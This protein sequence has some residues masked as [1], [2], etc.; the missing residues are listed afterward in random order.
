MSTPTKQTPPADRRPPA[1][2]G[3]RAV[4]GSA[5]VLAVDLYPRRRWLTIG[6]SA[7][8]GFL[9]TVVW[10]AE[11]VDS[12][13]GDTVANS[14]LGHD[15]KA[16]PIAGVGA[17]ILF[18]L[19][20]GLAGTFTACNV[21]VF[22][23]MAPALRGSASRMGR[24]RAVLRPLGW[25][26][27]GMVAV[28]AAYGVVVALVGTRMPQFQTAANVAGVLSPRSIQSMVVFGLVG[29]AM[30]YLGLAAA[31]VVRDPLARL[32]RRHPNAPMV[33]MGALVGAFLIGRPFG[34]FRALFRDAAESGNVLYGAAAFTLQSVGN[35]AVMAIALILL[36]QLAGNRLQ[37]W[38][39]ANPRRL[40]TLTTAAFVAAGVFTLLYWDLRLLERRGI[41]PWYPVAPWV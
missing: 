22:G 10:S 13:I 18:A 16:T 7:L 40:A 37:R 1:D 20:T 30:I 34:L 26:C 6:L 3:P 33:V 29:L 8:A 35:I 38:F 12:T 5:P 21:A 9:L 19:V 2:R 25:M 41:L 31:G 39:A 28:S 11:F 15:A 32:T 27:V 4:V 24:L 36:T 17:G 23:A 14:L